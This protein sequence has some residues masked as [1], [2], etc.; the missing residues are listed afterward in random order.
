MTTIR[1]SLE[2]PP[3]GNLFWINMGTWEGAIVKLYLPVQFGRLVL[4]L[5]CYVML[6]PVSD[7][8]S[9]PCSVIHQPIASFA[10][11]PRKQVNDFSAKKVTKTTKAVERDKENFRKWNKS[12][13][14]GK[15][16]NVIV[17]TSLHTCAELKSLPLFCQLDL[18]K[19]VMVLAARGILTLHKL[20]TTCVCSNQFTCRQ[21]SHLCNCWCNSPW[22]VQG[23]FQIILH[24]ARIICTQSKYFCIGM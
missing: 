14:I 16:S 23:H 22:I 2:R 5:A 6:C 7:P 18:M 21:R 11:F 19:K 24:T 3:I 13:V 9:L 4:K 8:F 1:N 10:I 15:Y 12:E 20:E 17:Q